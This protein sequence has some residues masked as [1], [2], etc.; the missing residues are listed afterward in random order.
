[1]EHKIAL[2][3]LN[4]LIE[5]TKSILSSW[6]DYIAKVNRKYDTSI[7]NADYIKG[8]KQK[9]K[10][11]LEK[12]VSVRFGSMY[13]SID[14]IVKAEEENESILDISN[15]ELQSAINLIN[16]MADKPNIV[17]SSMIVRTLR[18][19]YNSLVIIKRLFDAKNIKITGGS[20]K[21]FFK[22]STSTNNIKKALDALQGDITNVSK[23]IAFNRAIADYADLI[24][25]TLDAA[26]LDINEKEFA[27]TA[28]RSAM[29]I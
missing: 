3:E 9:A 6:K 29:G 25:E 22:P 23:L 17:I 26:E 16:T 21:Y 7:Y 27:N 20:E 18:G 12:I 15:A 13:E 5:D 10:E 14:K 28:I 11:E 19:D 2:K 24:G 1:M 8:Q 4:L